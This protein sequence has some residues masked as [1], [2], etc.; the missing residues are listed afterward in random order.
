MATIENKYAT[1]PGA[2]LAPPQSQYHD[3]SVSQTSSQSSAD[4][5][6]ANPFNNQATDSTPAP[7]GDA[8][9]L[10]ALTAQPEW[11]DCPNC[12]QRAQTEIQGR[13]K[14]KQRF[15]NVFWWPL[16]NRKHWW[17][18]VKWFCSNC[19]IQVASQKNGKNLQVLV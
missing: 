19:K 8:R 3:A 6:G 10:D 15:M 7:A 1:Q 12:H 4:N 14:G 2:D 16:P 17:E 18:E 11:I 13:S 5:N 9:P